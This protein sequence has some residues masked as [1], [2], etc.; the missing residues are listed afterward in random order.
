MHFR[1]QE[2]AH[3]LNSK[4]IPKSDTTIVPSKYVYDSRK[5]VFAIARFGILETYISIEACW[6][7]YFLAPWTSV[8]FQAY[9][10]T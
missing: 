1:E 3:C 10:P 2:T 9:P 4:V 8:A 7:N 5:L 6:P